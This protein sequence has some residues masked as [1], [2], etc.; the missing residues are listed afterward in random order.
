TA[1]LSIFR[2][3]FLVV[4]LALAL[5]PVSASAGI[6]DPYKTQ[7]WVGERPDGLAGVVSGSAPAEA[8]SAVERV[9]AERMVEYN[10]IAAKQKTSVAAVQ[11]I[12]G[13]KL[14]DQA[15]KGTYIMNAQGQWVKK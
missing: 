9:N 8:K 14:I 7:G 13:K 1:R 6:L 11:A 3:F 5:V 15:A 2:A 4:G 12:V 10:R